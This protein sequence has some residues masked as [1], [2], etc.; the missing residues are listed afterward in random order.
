M[1]GYWWPRTARGRLMLG[2][3]VVVEALLGLGSVTLSHPLSSVA[4]AVGFILMAP[5]TALAL[6]LFNAVETRVF[7]S[8]GFSTG[9]LAVTL[10]ALFALGALGNAVL[11]TYLRTSDPRF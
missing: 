8:V 1:R 10:T 11:M 6:P 3:Y 4:N 7:T 5:T 9:T 2:A